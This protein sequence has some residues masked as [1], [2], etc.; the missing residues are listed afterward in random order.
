M[1]GVSKPFSFSQIDL[2]TDKDSLHVSVYFPKSNFCIS[3][4]YSLSL[5][6]KVDA[7]KRDQ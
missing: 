2:S 4:L 1:F 7:N 6:L 3:C 5:I